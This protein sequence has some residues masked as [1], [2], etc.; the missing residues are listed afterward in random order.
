MWTE[1]LSKIKQTIWSL[2]PFSSYRKT[3]LFLSWDQDRTL[4]FKYLTFVFFLFNF[5]DFL[6]FLC[7]YPKIILSIVSFF[8]VDDPVSHRR[9]LTKFL[10]NLDEW[11]LRIAT[12]DVKLIHHQL[13]ASS[14][15]R[16]ENQI[17]QG[18]A[19]EWTGHSTLISENLKLVKISKNNFNTI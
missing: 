8:L 17:S 14:S 12:I 7:L 13:Q 19:Q 9:I 1:I 2:A 11:N 16:W 3:F 18:Q 15:S 6:E 5:N 4:K 10:E